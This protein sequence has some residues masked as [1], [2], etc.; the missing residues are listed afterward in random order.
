M[1]ILP[2]AVLWRGF[3]DEFETN[4]DHCFFP[5]CCNEM[6]CIGPRQVVPLVG[7]WTQY[8]FFIVWRKMWSHLVSPRCI[9]RVLFVATI[10]FHRFW[11]VVSF[12]WTKITEWLWFCWDLFI[13]HLSLSSTWVV[14]ICLIPL[15]SWVLSLTMFPRFVW[16][17]K[18]RFC[19]VWWICLDKW[20]RWSNHAKLSESFSL[21]E[22]P[23]LEPESGSCWNKSLVNQNFVRDPWKCLCAF[24]TCWSFVSK[25]WFSED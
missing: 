22:V 25:S 24:R 19:R 11:S 16:H 4:F 5:S 8:A 12:E 20:S 23:T 15:L 17:W 9:T 2:W 21:V 7:S 13:G 3:Q 14:T 6:D 1:P 18:P 10:F